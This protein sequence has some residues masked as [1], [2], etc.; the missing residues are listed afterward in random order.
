MPIVVLLEQHTVALIV[1]FLAFS[2]LVVETRH[3]GLAAAKAIP[4][5]GVPFVEGMP[6][7]APRTDEAPLFA[8]GV[9]GDEAAL[10]VDME[11]HSRDR[12]GIGGHCLP[13]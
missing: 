8:D 3:Q 9:A 11:I 7:R 4:Q 12:D 5:T 1:A 13:V 10:P 2:G 6:Q